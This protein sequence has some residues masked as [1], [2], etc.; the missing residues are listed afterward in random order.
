MPV[1][2]FIQIWTFYCYNQITFKPKV[3]DGKILAFGVLVMGRE[4]VV[5]ENMYGY[6]EDKE[7][8]K[9]IITE[10]C[11]FNEKGS[12]FPPHWHEQLMILYIEK[13]K[14]I[15][16][17]GN[18]Q[19]IGEQG[20]I[21]IVNPNVIHS[22]ENINSDLAYYLFKIDLLLLLGNQ[23]DLQQ[24]IY[25]ELLLKNRF[26]FEEKI[27]ED[28]FILG[29]IQK[30]IREYEE[31]KEGFE[32]VLRGLTY[33]ILTDL[34]RSYTKKIPEQSE[35]DIQYRKLNQIK[36]AI[37]H[38]EKHISEKITLDDLSKVSHLSPVHFSRVFKTVSGFPPMD[39]LNQMRVQKAA[40]LLITTDKTIIE[41]ALEVGFNDGNYFSRIFKKIKNETPSNFRCKYLK[42]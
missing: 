41:I 5:N 17:A 34:I 2:Q 39:F 8:S 24:S 16:Q 22:G 1:I 23:P 33:Q 32:L 19:I 14:M 20:T 25:T 9:P 13:G 12:I 6:V 29:S 10:Y 35:I 18:Q 28:E 27:T 31:K 21:L 30:M 40:Q 3:I 38:M 11:S 36:S 42:R 4:L 37:K 15:L 7:I 26:L